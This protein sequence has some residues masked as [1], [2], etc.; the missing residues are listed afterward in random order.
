MPVNLDA[1][2]AKE[3]NVSRPVTFRW[4]MA[5]VVIFLAGLG[6]T[7]WFWV[8]ERSG[9]KFWFTAVGLPVL[10]WGILFAV[11]RAG[12]KLDLV[13]ISSRNKSREALMASE[14]GRGQR[15]AWILGEY[16]VNA[17]EPGE[18]DT[19]LAAVNK[20]AILEHTLARDGVSSIRHS[21]LPEQG[22][23]EAI[24]NGYVADIRGQAEEMLAQLPENMPCYLAF[25]GS[26][27]I[28]SFADALISTINFPLRRIRNLSGFT[29][30]DYWLDRHHDIPAALLIVSV[31][32]YDVPPQDSGEAI[33]VMLLSNRRL[34]G[35]PSPAVRLHRPQMSKEGHLPLALSRAMLWAKLDNSAPLRGWISGGKLASAEVWS[36]ACT[37]MAPKLTAQ[38]NVSI[39]AAIGFAEAAAPWQSAILAYRQCL[40]DQEPQIIAIESDP[41]CHQLC[42]VTSEKKSGI[43]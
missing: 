27:N 11:R 39:D 36:N 7:L 13:G 32:I 1:I 6:I 33:A 23:P 10:F 25:D 37:A 21:A 19:H 4:S 15:F 16:L 31:Q 43:V 20:S 30:V 17:L 18:M 12:Y 28:E 29:I 41:S 26:D 40:T 24:F 34:S 42:V 2:P 22:K 3:P 5:F 8:G 38:R 14:I 9:L 35:M